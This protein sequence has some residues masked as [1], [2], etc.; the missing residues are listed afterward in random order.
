MC[1]PANMTLSCAPDAYFCLQLM[2]TDDSGIAELKGVANGFGPG[3][4][5]TTNGRTIRF[6]G[7]VPAATGP[8]SQ[9][10]IF[11]EATDDVGQ[12]SGQQLFALPVSDG[13]VP[14]LAV[15]SPAANS[16]VNGGQV[17]PL[18]LQLN[19]NFGVAEVRVGISG[20]FTTQIISPVTPAVSNGQT[21]VNI[22]VPTN[23]PSA[24]GSVTFSIFRNGCSS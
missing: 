11:A 24:G 8:G 18:T 10:Q 21:V 14:T 1:G 6:Q 15:V 12:V 23:V 22:T 7:I 17:V 19:D 5:I 13:T 16:L 9:I 4:I 20:G 3:G 2:A